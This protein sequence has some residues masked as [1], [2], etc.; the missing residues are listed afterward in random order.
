VGKSALLDY[1]AKAADARVLRARGCTRP[2]PGPGP[3]GAG[4]RRDAGR[5]PAGR[6][7]TGAGAAAGRFGQYLRCERALAAGTAAAYIAQAGRFLDGRGDTLE[8]LGASDVT[9]A[10][11]A[12]AE[13]VSAGSAQYFVAALGS[14]TWT[15]IRLLT[16]PGPPSR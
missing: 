10:V 3:D 6:A 14:A 16:W 7:G 9:A 12:E 5:G 8:G 2:E 11:L 13:K 1:A 15:A 4:R